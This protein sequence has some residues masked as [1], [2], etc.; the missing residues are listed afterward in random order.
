MEFNNNVIKDKV[1]GILN[2]CIDVHSDI[3]VCNK[4]DIFSTVTGVDEDGKQLLVNVITVRNN[5]VFPKQF[6]Q[7]RLI[8]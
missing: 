6:H 5:F 7:N 2:L 3:N 4:N 8:L 1:N